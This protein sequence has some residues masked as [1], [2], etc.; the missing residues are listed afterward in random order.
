M[1]KGVSMKSNIVNCFRKDIEIL[2]EGIKIIDTGEVI[3]YWDLSVVKLIG[4][5]TDNPCL[6]I[7]KF[8]N[9]S[10]LISYIGEVKDKLINDINYI[11]ESI[12][13]D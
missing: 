3:P 5:Y 10:Y 2:S 7:K 11:I 9:S 1:G 6:G 12:L 8:H 4:V 13:E